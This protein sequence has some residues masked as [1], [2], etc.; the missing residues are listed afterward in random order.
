MQINK[1]MQLFLLFLL[2]LL[3]ISC[4]KEQVKENTYLAFN[5]DNIIMTSK[6]TSTDSLIIIELLIKNQ[7]PN[8]TFWIPISHW[9]M[10]G[11]F[12][13]QGS[14]ANGFPFSNY[15]VNYFIISP[16]DSSLHTMIDK[17][18]GPIY[19]YFPKLW[20]IEPNTQKS[21]NI[22][23]KIP[24]LLEDD[25]DFELYS[26]IP[27]S[28]NF[29]LNNLFKQIPFAK[30]SSYLFLSDE[31]DLSLGKI[32]RLNRPWLNYQS[33]NIK[34][35]SIYNKELIETIKKE[36]YGSG[37]T[38]YNRMKA[39]YKDIWDYNNEIQEDI[40]FSNFNVVSKYFQ[41]YYSHK[42]IYTFQQELKCSCEIKTK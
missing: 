11:V 21:I 25:I 35:D 30:D 34:I 10:D 41:T 24:T 38:I 8:D 33:S 17:A 13:K 5:M 40:Y 23:F 9:E 28:N 3:L 14:L 37:N 31:L 1:K 39:E 27:I 7:N 26:F 4:N 19:D 6:A 22:T 36:S 32:S 29:N 16:K 18:P 20:Q 12:E 2:F 15:I 42:I